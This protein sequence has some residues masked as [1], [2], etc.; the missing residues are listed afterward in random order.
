MNENEDP[1][2]QARQV[3]RHLEAV[4]HGEHAMRVDQALSGG[5]V[6]NALLFTLREACETVLTAIEAIDPATE[7][8][9]EQWR[10]SIDKH[11]SPGHPAAPEKSR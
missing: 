7:T 2:D 6:G 9:L 4:G 10:L 11:L 3:A 1:V 8:L 5:G